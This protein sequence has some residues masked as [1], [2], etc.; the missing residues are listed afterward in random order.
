MVGVFQGDDADAVLVGEGDGAVHHFDGSKVA[1]RLMRVP[2][3]YRAQRQHFFRLGFGVDM[4]LVKLVDEAGK[5]VDAVRVNAGEG[6]ISKEGG[7]RLGGVLPEFAREQHALE[8]G[9]E[10][11]VG[12]LH[13]GIPLWFMNGKRAL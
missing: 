9:L 12:E 2:L 11:V 7:D 1:N 3:L 10:C 13:G 6:G 8:F 5:A 4:P